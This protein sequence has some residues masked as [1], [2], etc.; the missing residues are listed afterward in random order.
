[1]NQRLYLINQL[2]KT[3]LSAKAR[4]AVVN[5]LIISHL[6]YALLAIA[7]YCHVLTLLAM[8]PYFANWLEVGVS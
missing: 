4:E 7:G 2:R 5:L 6:L 1:V 3:G 8:M